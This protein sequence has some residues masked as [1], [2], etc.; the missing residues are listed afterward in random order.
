MYLHFF[1]YS[2]ESF[3]HQHWQISHRSLS[4]NRF[5]QVSK[6][7]LSILADLNNAV[8]WMVSIWPLISKSSSPFTNCLRIV[9]SVPITIDITVT[10][11]FHNFFYSSCKV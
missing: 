1:F 9:P 4:D 3:P 6:T 2:F 7:I 5:P 11:M 8:A 10:F